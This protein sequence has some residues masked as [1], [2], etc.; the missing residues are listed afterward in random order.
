MRNPQL[1]TDVARTDAAVRQ[2]HNLPSNHLWQGTA[3]DEEAAELVNSALPIGAFCH[4]C[5]RQLTVDK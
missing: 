3:V 1:S 2:L 4:L 5:G